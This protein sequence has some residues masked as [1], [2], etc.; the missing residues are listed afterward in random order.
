MSK[1]G[2][3][4][5]LTGIAGSGAVPNG[6][7]V[8]GEIPKTPGLAVATE[9]KP[10]EPAALDSDRFAVLAKKEAKVQREREALAKEKQEID[11]LKAKLKDPYDKIQA[12]EAL[13][14][15]DPIAALKEIGFTETD[16]F[17][18]MAGAEKKE[19]TTAE[20]AAAAAK[21]EINRFK[22]EQTSAAKELQRTRDEK[23]VKDHKANVAK[24]IEDNK[25]TY[26]YVAFHGP[27]AQELVENVILEVLEKEGKLIP[28][29]EALELVEG[30]YEENDKAMSSLKKRQPKVEEVPVKVEPAR[31]RTVEAPKSQPQKT[32]T[33][34]VSAT[35]ASSIP[36]SESREQKKQRLMDALRSGAI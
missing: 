33:N 2:A 15:K 14:A 31:T 9:V 25:E 16:I 30:W 26:E 8:T 12:F 3:L 36:R 5:A 6:S 7:L 35:A 29:K 22:E 27:V 28:T 10:E 23:I 19:P 13:K 34:R 11:E 20:L 18:F 24:T 1:E 21:E 17:N 4:K 32:L